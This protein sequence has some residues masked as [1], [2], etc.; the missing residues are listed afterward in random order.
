V[1][2]CIVHLIRNSL[3]YFTLA[4][5]KAVAAALRSV[6]TAPTEAAAHDALAAFDAGEWGGSIRPSPRRGAATG[7]G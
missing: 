2:T 1:Q 5:R 4:N 7:N 3:D 6:Y